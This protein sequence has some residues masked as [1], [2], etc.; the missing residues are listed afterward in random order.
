MRRTP[1]A[2]VRSVGVVHAADCTAPVAVKE[3]ILELLQMNSVSMAFAVFS[4]VG[5]GLLARAGRVK[6]RRVLSTFAAGGMDMVGCVFYMNMASSGRRNRDEALSRCNCAAAVS[7]R[8]E[9]S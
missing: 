2:R 1:T 6:L 8:F 3:T 5:G 4:G 7:V 9:A